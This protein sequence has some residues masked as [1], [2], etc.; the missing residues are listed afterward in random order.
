MVLEGSLEPFLRILRNLLKKYSKKSISLV[1]NQLAKSKKRS[2]KTLRVK[3]RKL[4]K[5]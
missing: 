3:L 1:S 4:T 5:S 2:G